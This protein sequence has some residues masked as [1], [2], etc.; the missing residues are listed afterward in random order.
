[1]G[2]NNANDLIKLR[3]IIETVTFTVEG[4]TSKVASFY[5]T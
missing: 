1:M 4:V 3:L 5:F 2:K